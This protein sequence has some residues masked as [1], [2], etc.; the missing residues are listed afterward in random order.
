MNEGEQRFIPPVESERVKPEKGDERISSIETAIEGINQRLDRLR[1][2]A[3]ET[4]VPGERIRNECRRM[5]CALGLRS[6]T[7]KALETVL[8]IDP[9]FYK[10]AALRGDEHPEE[11]FGLESYKGWLEARLYMRGIDKLTPAVIKQ[12]HKLLMQGM[13]SIRPGEYRNMGAVGGDYTEKGKPVNV[14]SKQLAVLQGS[15]LTQFDILDAGSE[16]NTRGYIIYPS[17]ERR[18]TIRKAIAWLSPERS[19]KLTSTVVTEQRLIEFLVEEAVEKYEHRENTSNTDEY[20]AALLQRDIVSIHPF[21]DGNGRLSRLLMNWALEKKGKM[22]CYLENPGQDMLLDEKEWERTVKQG[23]SDYNL[24]LVTSEY[25][26]LGKPR[27]PREVFFTR[28]VC[29]Y[30]DI[31]HSK[32]QIQP[33]PEAQL[34]Y[35]EQKASLDQFELDAVQFTE[36][37]G[38]IYNPANLVNGDTERDVEKIYVGGLIPESYRENWGITATDVEK[39]YVEGTTLYRGGLVEDYSE[40]EDVLALFEGAVGLSSSY[41]ACFE[42]G[43]SPMSIKGISRSMILET[44]D[45]YNGI[46]AN[47]WLTK[48]RSKPFQEFMD[49]ELHK[50]GPENRYLGKA[51][52]DGEYM[53][54]LVGA[55]IY[56]AREIRISP[57]VS[58]STAKETSEWWAGRYRGRN[59]VGLLMELSVPKR[60]VLISENLDRNGLQLPEPVT[61]IASHEDEFLL[62]GGIDPNAIKEVEIIKNSERTQNRTICRARRIA[63]RVVILDIFET[64]ERRYYEFDRQGDLQ[65]T[66]IETLPDEKLSS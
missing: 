20:S 58:T 36:S 42:A 47:D 17:A 37:T 53:E 43:I 21:E 46:V 40:P 29:D 34:V 38:Y 54:A 32:R 59:N 19:E 45:T 52:E 39:T 62:V 63:K 48:H 11:L 28:Q 51:I 25:A 5:E 66:K 57:F 64:K 50:I 26:P 27:T 7:D 35:E 60:G 30:Y 13:R 31:V 2:Q 23:V 12:A 55:H 8:F 10:G 15:P 65:I 6:V 18:D 61:K 33:R 1:R 9:P 24:Y 56:S 22:P 49:K 16:G 3:R 41:R 44:M 4:L 14:G